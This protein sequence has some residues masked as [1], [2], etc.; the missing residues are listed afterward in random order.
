[1]EGKGMQGLVG[2]DKGAANMYRV[3]NLLMMGASGT[4]WNTVPFWPVAMM[5]PEFETAIA[6]I[7]ISW[8]LRK[9]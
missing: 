6:E 7:S 3:D 2:R 4:L 9:A 8:P 1:M 5:F